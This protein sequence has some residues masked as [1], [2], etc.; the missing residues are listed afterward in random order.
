VL[1]GPL[2][3]LARI[4]SLGPP[5][6]VGKGLLILRSVARHR[7]RLLGLSRRRAMLLVGTPGV[8][9]LGVP[10]PLSPTVASS[11]DLAPFLGSW[12]WVGAVGAAGGVGRAEEVGGI[13]GRSCWRICSVLSCA[14]FLR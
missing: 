3:L 10:G 8:V 14:R 1:L 2:F 7:G 9:V 12:T 13:G 4:L 6:V 11:L 5:Y